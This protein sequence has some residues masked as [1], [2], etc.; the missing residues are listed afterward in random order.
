MLKAIFDRTTTNPLREAIRGMAPA[1]RSVAA[2]SLFLNLLIFA[3]SLYMESGFDRVLTSRNLTTWGFLTVIL[4]VLVATHGVLSTY[5][6]R[7]FVRIGI[8]FDQKVSDPLFRAIHRAALQQGPGGGR[9]SPV[10][11]MRDL[12]IVRENLAGRLVSNGVDLLF[13]PVFLLA[14]TLMHPVIGLTTFL[15]LAGVAGCGFAINLAT[16]SSTLRATAA[17]VHAN[18]FATS[19]MRNSE[20]I[21]ALGMIETLEAR[22][23]R[24]RDAGLGWQAR[25]ADEANVAQVTLATLTFAGSTVVVAVALVLIVLNMASAGILFGAMIISAK[26]IAPVSSLSKN[27]KS[28]V[29]TSYSF[30]RIDR[31]FNQLPDLP[32]RMALPRPS[33]HILVDNVSAMAPGSNRLVLRNL[34]FELGAGEVMAVIGPS[35]AGKSSLARVLMGIWPTFEG[36]VR[37]DGSELSHW[38]PDELGKHVGY[39]PQDVELFAGTVAENIARFRAASSE[40]VIAAARLAGVHEM[41][42]GLPEGY[43]TEIGESGLRLSGGQRQRLALARAIIGQPALIVL[44][45]PNA[46]LDIK[47]EE[48]LA[49]A[50][51]Q[52]RQAGSSVIII[53]HRSNM[54]SQVDRVLVLNDGTAHLCGPRDEVMRKLGMQNVVAMTAPPRTQQPVSRERPSER[55]QE[56]AAR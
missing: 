13:V 18:E 29:S 2:I 51:R 56:G 43:N 23:K 15:V 17:G 6:Q 36:S 48:S 41:I 24:V 53:T 33:G 7:I 5:R 12:D 38:N 21:H 27:W 50:I 10:Q 20:V 39:V 3:P 55:Q 8:D 37:I 40:E 42:Q 35:A 31:I 32:E 52:L 26:A 54:I 19:L 49:T 25:S 45:E 44:D 4:L 47:G 16:A 9:T 22:W 46:S 14:L 30:E 11:A 28:Y 34:S 1:M